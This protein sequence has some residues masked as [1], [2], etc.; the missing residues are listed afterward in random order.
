MCHQ[1]LL[2]LSSYQVASI[3]LITG[4]TNLV[5]SPPAILAFTIVK[6]FFTLLPFS[7][8]ELQTFPVKKPDYYK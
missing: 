8:R 2:C 3:L 4:D 7:Y 1:A 6:V 5:A